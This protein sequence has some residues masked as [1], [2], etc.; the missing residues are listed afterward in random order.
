[1]STRTHRRICNTRFSNHCTGTTL[2][3]FN[4]IPLNTTT[5]RQIFNS[6]EQERR[7]PVQHLT[8]HLSFLDV[9]PL[10]TIIPPITQESVIQC[11]ADGDFPDEPNSEDMEAIHH[12]P[13]TGAGPAGAAGE[14]NEAESLDSD[15]NST[16]GNGYL[17]S[18]AETA[19]CGENKDDTNDNTT[20]LSPVRSGGRLS[21][22]ESAGGSLSRSNDGSSR[23]ND[24]GMKIMSSLRRVS[25]SLSTRNLMSDEDR[26]LSGR[27][28]GEAVQ[29]ALAATNAA[30]AVTLSESSFT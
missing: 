25:S 10:K 27:T 20:R 16:D 29:A 11:N 7:E 22:N 9:I 6:V 23:S 14:R 17:V 1:M 2:H 18:A 4:S 3:T 13:F 8:S 30:R 12:A 19:E 5:L 24:R 26:E 28:L 15:F 21:S